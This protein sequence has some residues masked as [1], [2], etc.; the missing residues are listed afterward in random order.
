LYH[1]KMY[2]KG[3]L[4]KRRY[5]N[6]LPAFLEKI[7]VKLD[8]IINYFSFKFKFSNLFWKEFSKVY[9]YFFDKQ[10]KKKEIFQIPISLIFWVFL[11][12]LKKSK[13][14]IKK[15][16]KSWLYRNIRIRQTFWMELKKKTPKFFSYQLF[17]FNKVNSAIQ[18]DFITNYFSVLKDCI[19]FESINEYIFNNKLLKMHNF[20][21]KS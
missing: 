11:N 16:V 19:S 10:L 4:K 17:N 14:K 6:F 20:R 9:L 8:V 1:W 5:R 18:Y 2:K 7:K 12:K 15:K 21:F 13:R 3:T